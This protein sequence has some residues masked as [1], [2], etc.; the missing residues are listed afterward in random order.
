MI[1]SSEVDA[2]EVQQRAVAGLVD[3]FAE[4]E[5][6]GE[7]GAC[8]DLLEGLE[9]IKSAA[10]AA[11]ARVTDGLDR[12]RSS[13]GS[14]RDASLGAEIG[15]A[16]REPPHQG[17]GH[18]SLARALLH[19]LPHTYRALCRG[20]LSVRRDEIIATETGVLSRELRLLVDAEVAGDPD[21]LEGLGEAGLQQR[22]R[23]VVLRVDEEA[24]LA[25][26]RRAHTCRRLT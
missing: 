20:D 19:D 25:R 4:L 23:R 3:W 2:A 10:A 14:R 7:D 22:V 11:Q 12:R 24:A 15:L 8:I 18:L 21:S 26:H 5:M 13:R 6:P 9:R 16:R 17:R 1:E